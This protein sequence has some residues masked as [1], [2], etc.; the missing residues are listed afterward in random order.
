ML[1]QTKNKISGFTFIELMISVSIFMLIGG[2]MLANFRSGDQASELTKSAETVASRLR[3]AQTRALSGVGG[4]GSNGHGIY[5]QNNGISFVSYQDNLNNSNSFAYNS[6]EVDATISLQKHVTIVT[7]ADILFAVPSGD[8]YQSGSL[9][10]TGNATVTVKHSVS[11]LQRDINIS[12]VSG[13]VTISDS[14]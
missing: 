11:G 12:A 4:V 7:V 8:L 5:L 3:E 13:Q 6:V 14:Y 2:M 9:L 10:S 1:I